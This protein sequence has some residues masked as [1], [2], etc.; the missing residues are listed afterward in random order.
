M[1]GYIY[2]TL[3]LTF[4]LI[5]AYC[6]KR[7]STAAVHLYDAIAINTVR[8]IL[9]VVIGVIF[10]LLGHKSSMLFPSAKVVLIALLCGLGTACFTVC[11][12]LSVR[13]EAYMLVEVFV[14]AGSIIP[15][16]LCA[17]LYKESVGAAQILAITLLLTAVYCMCTAKTNE[18]V[19]FSSK[20]LLLLILCATTSGISDFS[21]KLFVLEC[22]SNNI[23]LF[24]LYVYLF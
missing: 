1:I 7:T 15:L 3:A 24:N 22:G 9:C 20:N 4:G 18:K 6:G 17:A 5:K 21:Q 13:T 12:L 2:L 14:M 23:S 11:W 10:I 16:T 19:R 8:M